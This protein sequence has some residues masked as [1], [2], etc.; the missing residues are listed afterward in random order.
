[1]QWNAAASLLLPDQLWDSNQH[2]GGLKCS[3]GKGTISSTTSVTYPLPRQAG[4][5]PMHSIYADR[6]HMCA[7]VC[8]F[9]FYYF[10]FHIA[11][12]FKC[13]SWCALE[14]GSVQLSDAECRGLMWC[15]AVMN[16]KRHLSACKL[17]VSELKASQCS[18]YVLNLMMWEIWL[19]PLKGYFVEQFIWSL[20]K[21]NGWECKINA[22][23]ILQLHMHWP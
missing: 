8:F 13:A 3:G 1:M 23:Q 18:Y 11:M 7:T 2:I 21:P 9:C 16:S 5:L 22:A 6:V 19:P 17:V 10:F 12:V 14:M 20:T 15:V 4:A